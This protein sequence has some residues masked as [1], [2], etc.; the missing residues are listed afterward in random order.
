[1]NRHARLM[2]VAALSG[3]FAGA[4]VVV[5]A[6]EEC[7]SQHAACQEQQAPKKAET[8]AAQE[9]KPND[10]CGRQEPGAAS[11]EPPQALEDPKDVE[12]SEAHQRWLES[13]WNS[14]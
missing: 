10:P 5:A 11:P 2:V 8:K 4:P 12:K 3:A 9:C 1:M 14:P 7:E 13:I 6:Q